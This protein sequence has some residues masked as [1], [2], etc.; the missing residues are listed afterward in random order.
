MGLNYC[1]VCGVLIANVAPN[2]PATICERC[3][4][5]RKVLLGSD[6]PSDAR[7][8]DTPDRV[9]FACPSCRSI[10]QLPPVKKRTKIKCP[11]CRADFAMHP[12]G[13]IERAGGTTKLPQDALL[14]DLKPQRELDDLLARVPEK[15]F[16]ALPKILDS[17]SASAQPEIELDMLPQGVG[18]GDAANPDYLLLPDNKGEPDFPE[19]KE[20]DPVKLGKDL[21]KAPK[22]I[23]TAR[24]T[25]EQVYEKR[26]E[27]EARAK[28]AQEAQKYTLALLEQRRRRALATARLVALVLGPLLIGSLF[29]IST[30]QEGGFAVKGGLGRALGDLGDTA[31]RGVEGVLSLTGSK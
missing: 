17:G 3:F 6:P 14:G 20:L 25:K 29:L 31:R 1:E 5:S 21:E 4:A 9:Q 18:P 7:A 10:L 11:Q 16:E 27:Q 2:A 23:A 8:T 19:S 28:R 22:K 15:K 26:K 30:T 12:D 13:R 24:R